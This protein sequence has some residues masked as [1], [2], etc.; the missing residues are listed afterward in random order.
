MIAYLTS[1]GVEQAILNPATEGGFR[2]ESTKAWFSSLNDIIAQNPSVLMQ[3]LLATSPAPP[4]LHNEEHAAS[5]VHAD[6]NSAEMVISNP[7]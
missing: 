2:L 1:S 7:K 4:R 3:G 5:S 6:L